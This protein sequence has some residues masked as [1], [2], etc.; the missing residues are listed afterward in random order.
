M[1][2]PCQPIHEVLWFSL[3]NPDYLFRKIQ[4]SIFILIDCLPLFERSIVGSTHLNHLLFLFSAKQKLFQD[5]LK[6]YRQLVISTVEQSRIPVYVLQYERI[7]DNLEKE[8]KMLAEFLNVEVSDYELNCAIQLQEGHAHRKT[9]RAERI[10]LMHEVFSDKDIQELETLQLDVEDILSERV[11][12][13]Y[14]LSGI[15]GRQ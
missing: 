14:D 10:K 8:L 12:D 11:H 4:S 1:Y 13:T 2:E 5:S 3:L 15:I 7:K 9:S 6:L